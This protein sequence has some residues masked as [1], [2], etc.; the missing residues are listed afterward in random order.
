MAVKHFYVEGQLG[1]RALLFIPHHA[2]FD[3]FENKKKNSRLYIWPV[4]IMDNYD[5]II[6]EYLNFIYCVV[7]SKDLPLNISREMMQQSKMK[8]ILKNSKCLEFFLELAV[9][10]E[11]MRRK[12]IK[13]R[14]RQSLRTSVS[15]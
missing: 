7:N 3:L 8:V 2:S 4:F 5:K 15:L 11:R 10:K 6:P 12:I 13:W 9:D 14:A 1:F